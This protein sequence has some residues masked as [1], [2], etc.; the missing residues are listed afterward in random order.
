V[1]VASTFFLFAEKQKTGEQEQQLSSPGFS[2]VPP[3]RPP[4]SSPSPSGRFARLDFGALA[5]WVSQPV[6]SRGQ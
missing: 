6:A 2:M 3:K 5:G 4:K 1:E